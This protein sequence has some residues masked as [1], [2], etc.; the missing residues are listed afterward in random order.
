LGKAKNATIIVKEREALDVDQ[1]RS[2]TNGD[3][4]KSHRASGPEG[5][6]D[7]REIVKGETSLRRHSGD[8]EKKLRSGGQSRPVIAGGEVLK[9][10]L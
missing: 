3:P 10:G 2:G 5:K 6:Y 4:G 1:R 7:G 9:A 8:F